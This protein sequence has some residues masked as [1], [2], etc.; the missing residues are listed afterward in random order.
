M[1]PYCGLYS[2][3]KPLLLNEK[4]PYSFSYELQVIL[5]QGAMTLIYHD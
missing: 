2:R 4:I 1:T 3:N 5:N